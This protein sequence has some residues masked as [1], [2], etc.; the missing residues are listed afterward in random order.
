MNT[1]KNEEVFPCGSKESLPVRAGFFKT[2]SELEKPNPKKILRSGYTTGACAAAAT[3]AALQALLGQKKID[4][5][6]I[7]LPAGREVTFSLKSCVFQKDS[8]HASIIKDAGD[9]PDATHK[10]EIVS[11]V[12]FND[13]G[14]I[15]FRA[16]LGVGTFT[17]PGLSYSPGEPAINPVPRAM[18]TQVCQEVAPGRGVDITISVPDGEKIAKRTLNARLGIQGGISILGTTGIVKPYSNAAYVA[19]ITQGIDVAYAN[20]QRHLVFNAGAKSEKMT[21]RLFDL[22]EVCFIQYGNFVGEALRYAKKY[23]LSKISVCAMIGKLVKLAAGQLDLHSSEG[24][25]DAGFLRDTAKKIGVSE[26]LCEKIGS[27][28]M[29]KT[30]LEELPP[31]VFSKFYD[32]LC[33]DAHRHG[34]KLLGPA[35]GLEI[36]LLD[37]SGKVI[38]KNL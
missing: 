14:K 19:S 13:A 35:I 36:L 32:T 21:Q 3:K 29:A 15:S 20:G 18:M 12:R 22:P 38:G 9:D 8:A 25:F 28:R 6:S 17:I 23:K 11:S 4:R 1:K 27:M 24:S 26:P 10:A 37:E 5:V 30:L 33:A 16:G 34:A 7:R 31:S 2:D